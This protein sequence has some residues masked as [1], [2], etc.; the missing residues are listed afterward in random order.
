[1]DRGHRGNFVVPHKHQMLT[2]WPPP[3]HPAT[4][5]TPTSATKITI[6]GCRTSRD[7]AATL[8]WVV[9]GSIFVIVAGQL[10]LLSRL[11]PGLRESALPVGLLGDLI[12]LAGNVGVSVA[13]TVIFLGPRLTLA[14]R[15]RN[16]LRDLDPLSTHLLASYPQVHVDSMKV[17]W[18]RPSLRAERTLI[19][20][21]DALCLLRV[22]RGSQNP[23]PFALVSR[24]L[25]SKGVP[26]EGCSDAAVTVL[27][28]PR[29]RDEEESML[30]TLS[31]QVRA[32][33]S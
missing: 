23:C 31:R 17:P 24:T 9:R 21:S 2:R 28:T 1:M 14:R 33:A 20:I 18:W 12:T 3:T 8:N 19:E 15:S 26:T 25:L 4:P 27:P 11:A 7:P 30:V 32:D 10:V 16:L 13:N 22:P 6:Y 5:P 29:T